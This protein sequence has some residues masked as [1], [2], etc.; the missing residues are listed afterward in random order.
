[1]MSDLSFPTGFE[2]LPIG[3]CEWV[4]FPQLGIPAIKAKIDTG[5]STSCIHAFD[6]D[7]VSVND[8]KLVRFKTFPLQ[9]RQDVLK[10]CAALFVDERNVTDSGGHT[11]HRLVIATELK[12]GD[13]SWM[14]EVTLT[15]R[16]A[17]KYRMLMGRQAM[18]NHVVIHPHQRY[19][20]GKMKK[21]D[22]RNMYF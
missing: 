15:N 4:S 21:A 17:M 20:Q 22:L 18:K 13:Q 1:M 12:I 5:A 9:S 19:L 6:I 10:T 11:E 16:S 8:V 7:M 14:V 2:P 3:W